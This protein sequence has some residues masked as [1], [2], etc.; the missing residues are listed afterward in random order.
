MNAALKLL[1]VLD[2]V[3]NVA[4]TS[5]YKKTEKAIFSNAGLCGE[6]KISF[7]AGNGAQTLLQQSP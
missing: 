6:N 5:G 2:K 1:G 7:P 3:G 4:Y